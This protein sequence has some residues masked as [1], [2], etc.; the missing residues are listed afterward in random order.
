MGHRSLWE[1]RVVSLGSFHWVWEAYGVYTWA[2]SRQS[3]FPGLSSEDSFMVKEGDKKHL[4][5][6]P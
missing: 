2:C 5:Y 1:G 6:E 3:G 4:L